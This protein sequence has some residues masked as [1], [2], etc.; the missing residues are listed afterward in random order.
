MSYHNFFATI[1]LGTQI[2]S[3]ARSWTDRGAALKPRVYSRERTL[4][5]AVGV[6]DDGSGSVGADG[7]AH[8]T[9]SILVPYRVRD[10]CGG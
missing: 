9:G 3:R 6:D 2:L 7:A 4:G 10:R 5:A 1:K 8:H